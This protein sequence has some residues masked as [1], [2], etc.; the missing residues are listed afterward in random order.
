MAKP[1]TVAAFLSA[2]DV[3]VERDRDFR[4][5]GE[6]HNPTISGCELKLGTWHSMYCGSHTLPTS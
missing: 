1:P 2:L 5:T 4:I 3:V 6:A